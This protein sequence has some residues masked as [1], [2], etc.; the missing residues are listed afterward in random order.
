M[1]CESYGH[2]TTITTKNG[3]YEVRQSL[4]EL[5]Q[6]LDSSFIRCHRSYIAGLRHISRI[7]KNEVILD[8]G[9]ALPLSRRLYDSVNQAFINFFKGIS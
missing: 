9:T 8:D 2:I 4:T 7:T 1:V 5:E 6:Q 3:S